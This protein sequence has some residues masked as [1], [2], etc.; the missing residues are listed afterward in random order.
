[1]S[2]DTDP[3]VTLG[4]ARAATQAEIKAAYFRAVAES[5]PETHPV[6]FQQIQEAYRTLSNLERRRAFDE[7]EKVPDRLRK[8]LAECERRYGSDPEP[9]EWH[10]RKLISEY[11]ESSKPRMA[12]ATL[13]LETKRADKAIPVLTDIVAKDPVNATHAVMLGAALCEI[14]SMEE[15]IAHLKHAIVLDGSRI[16][17]YRLL[18][19]GLA[20]LDRLADARSVLER[21]ILADG[22]V[23]LGDL[24]LYIDLLLIHARSNDWP[25]MQSTVDQFVHAIPKGDREANDHI[26]SRVAPV[27]QEFLK[28]GRANI[29]GQFVRLL[30][31]VDPAD[32]RVKALVGA[33]AAN[34]HASPR[35]SEIGQTQPLDLMIIGTRLQIDGNRIIW[36]NAEVAA[37]DA[38]GFTWGI[39]QR[40]TNGFR[41]ECSYRVGIRFQS[42]EVFTIE[43]HERKFLGRLTE[44]AAQSMSAFEKVVGALLRLVVPITVNSIVESLKAGATHKIGDCTITKTGIQF[45]TGALFWKKQRSIPWGR[46]SV[47]P[48]E[49]WIF[50][51]DKSG[52]IAMMQLNQR[53]VWNAVLFPILPGVME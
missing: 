36:A 32:N 2:S 7:Q 23:D 9:H 24:P 41:T 28:L 25:S 40:Y 49:G 13:Y 29:A 44:D 53:D 34:E 18:A 21:G 43:C 33:V 6:R 14:G 30:Q 38:T 19:R 39:F 45:T 10:L 48:R 35:S 46:V 50:V 42:G 1:M 4:V 26:V 47:E 51:G 8:E 11:P 27:A 12:L 52:D 31:I 37:K 20:K 17:A 15:A 22:V 16:D 3:Y 5:P